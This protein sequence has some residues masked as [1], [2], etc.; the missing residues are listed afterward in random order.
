MEQIEKGRLVQIYR[1]DGSWTVRAVNKET[2]LNCLNMRT[3]TVTPIEYEAL[4]TSG[5]FLNYP[6]KTIAKHFEKHGKSILMWCRE[7]RLG[8]DLYCTDPGAGND[9]IITRM[10]KI[11]KKQ[12]MAFDDLDT[13]E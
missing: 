5:R 4:K 12:C 13:G 2:C 9:T 8:K 1:K 6:Q 11:N 10:R 3:K 7:N